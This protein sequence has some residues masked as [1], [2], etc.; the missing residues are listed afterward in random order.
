MTELLQRVVSEV[1]LLDPEQQDAIAELI[2]QELEE[3]EWDALV[4]SPA[5]QAVLARMAA[6]A[7]RDDAAGETRESGDSW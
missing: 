4:S 5:S 3:R 7:L 6:D 1:E 2:Q